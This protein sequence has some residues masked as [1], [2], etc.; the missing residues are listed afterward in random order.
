MA[1]F[2]DVYS[3]ATGKKTRVPAHWE[4]NPKL[5]APFEK[6]PRQKAAD[7]E[8]ELKGK[9]LDAALEE[10]GLPTTGT[11]A[12]K[13]AA[14]AEHLAADTTDPLE[15]TDGSNEPTEPPHGGEP[16]E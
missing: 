3:K 6:T 5:F 1:E 9:A 15:T 14:L 11:A 4:K 10:A 7:G 8:V 12:E 2:I 16:K 13:R